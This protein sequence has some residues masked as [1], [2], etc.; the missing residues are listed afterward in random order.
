ML[1]QH[2]AFVSLLLLAGGA[3]WT[4]E[5]LRWHSGCMCELSQEA[6]EDVGFATS[7]IFDT[8][9]FKR[10]GQISEFCPCS[11]ESIQSLNHEVI[12]PVG[13]YVIMGRGQGEFFLH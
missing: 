10:N 5:A 2:V 1:G 6:G 8:K 7:H 12:A 9:F 3:G 11:L 4:A 13:G